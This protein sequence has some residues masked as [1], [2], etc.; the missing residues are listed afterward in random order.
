VDA[1]PPG[2]QHTQKQIGDRFDTPVA[3]P[4]IARAARSENWCSRTAPGADDTVCRR[5]VAQE[6]PS[7]EIVP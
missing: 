3:E 5:P 1:V 4:A 6:A 7:Q 2:R